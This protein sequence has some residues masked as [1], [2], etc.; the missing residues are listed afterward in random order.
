MASLKRRGKQYYAQYYVGTNQKRI[1][2]DTTSLTVAKERLRQLESSLYR[3]EDIPLPTRTPISYRAGA[4]HRLHADAEDHQEPRMRP[5]LSP[6]SI[7]P[8]FT[9]KH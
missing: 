5:I 7:W 4:L 1:N 2:L 3:G 8:S 6:A 9:R